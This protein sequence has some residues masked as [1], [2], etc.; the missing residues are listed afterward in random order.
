MKSKD[1]TRLPSYLEIVRQITGI[2]SLNAYLREV[3]NRQRGALGNID[4]SRG[5][6]LEQLKQASMGSELNAYLDPS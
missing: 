5:I 1:L 2:A 3:L 6:I 4:Y